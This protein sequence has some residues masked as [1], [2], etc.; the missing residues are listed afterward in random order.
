MRDKNKGFTLIELLV[1]V[2]I[3]GI[4]ASVGVVAYNGYTTSAKKAGV[5]SNHANVMKTLG[6]EIAKCNIDDEVLKAG[7]GDSATK[8][9]CTGRTAATT[10]TAAIAFFNGKSD[11]YNNP[12][13]GPTLIE[14]ADAT[15]DIAK[16]SIRLTADGSNVKIQSCKSPDGCALTSSDTLSGA[17][18]ID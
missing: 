13:D 2:A 11:E 9:T 8:L 10:I 16:G 17:V 3:I 14:A 4:L 7:S 1:V 15:D 6:A 18:S 12:F 5:A